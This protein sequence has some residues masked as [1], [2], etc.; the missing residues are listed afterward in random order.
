MP[1]KKQSK[2]TWVLDPAVWDQVVDSPEEDAMIREDNHTIDAAGSQFSKEISDSDYVPSEARSV[3][4]SE[5]DSNNEANGEGWEMNPGDLRAM[6]E[7]VM[8]SLQ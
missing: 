7:A 5:L 1:Q 8:P 6:V 2:S 3:L 4:L